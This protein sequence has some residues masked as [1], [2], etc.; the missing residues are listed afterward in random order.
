MR[1]YKFFIKSGQVAFIWVILFVISIS[2]YSITI[3]GKVNYGDRCYQSINEDVIKSYQYEGVLLN[4]GYLACNTYYLE[5]KS[6]LEEKDNVIFLAAVAKLL[7]DNDITCDMHIII[8]CKDY[9]IIATI[10]DYNISYTK[11]L[12]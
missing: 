2:L 10:V 6:E 5:Y 12:I 3:K 4:N 8:K 7:S 11:S 9:Q 1:I